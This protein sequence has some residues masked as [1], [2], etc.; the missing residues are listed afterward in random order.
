MKLPLLDYDRLFFSDPDARS[1]PYGM[2]TFASNKQAESFMAEIYMEEEESDLINFDAGCSCRHIKGNFYVGMECPKCKTVVRD[3]FASEIKFKAWLT[4]PEYAPPMLHPAAYWVLKKWMGSTKNVFLL[5][6]LLS[7]DLAD[8]MPPELLEKVGCGY[9][10]FYDN[11]DIIIAYLYNEYPPF[12]TSQVRDKGKSIPEYIEKYRDIMFIHHV[13]ILNSNLH[14]MTSNGSIK[15]IDVTSQ[16]IV[17]CIV[18]LSNLEYRQSTGARPELYLDQQIYSIYN[19]YYEYVYS[20]VD[21]KLAKK[22]GYIR[23]HM[24]GSRLHFTSRAVILPIT[25]EHDMDEIYI[26]WRMGVTMYGLEIH[27]LLVNRYGYTEPDAMSKRHNA[28]FKYDPE[29]SDIMKTLIA[30]AGHINPDGTFEKFKGLCVI[31]GRNPTLR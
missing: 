6:C 3:A 8:K 29:I 28:L 11:F 23:R 22:P 13:P 15:F 27:N 7:V 14:L 2:E 12:Q 30:E 19:C 24:V 26:P 4:L 9:R 20:I 16:H 31:F 1:V 25:G 18:E 21:N 10:N 17:K 5:D